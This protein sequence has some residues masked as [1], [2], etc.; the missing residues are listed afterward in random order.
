M[1]VP[2][3]PRGPAP[4]DAKDPRTWDH[5]KTVEWLTTQFTQRAMKSREAGWKVKANAAKLAGRKLKPLEKPEPGQLD[6]G[7]DILTICPPGSTAK[8]LGMLYT[9]QFVQRCLEARRGEALTTDQLKNTAVEMIGNLFY[10]IITAKTKKRNEI[11]KSRKKLATEIYGGSASFVSSS[12]AYFVL[13]PGEA[14][15]RIREYDEEEFL[16][17]QIFYGEL[18]HQVIR[19]I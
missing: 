3:K 17:A 5:D 9:P 1:T 7:V 13:L 4:Y 12:D 16:E 6:L 10:L 14:P 2:P 8:N 15:R 18:T 19:S 11:M